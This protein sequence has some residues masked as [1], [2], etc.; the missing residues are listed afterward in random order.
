VPEHDGEARLH[1]VFDPGRLTRGALE[2]GAGC[3]CS[4]VSRGAYPFDGDL[5]RSRALVEAL[6]KDLERRTG[7]VCEDSDATGRVKDPDLL[8]RDPLAG[9]RLLCRIDA[10]LLTGQAFMA[11]PRTLGMLPREVLVI[12]EPKLERYLARAAADRAE[13]GRNVPA[14]VVWHYG[15]RCRGLT[16]VTVFQEV[17]ELDRIRERMG[18][19]RRFRRAAGGGD[20]RDGRRWGVIDKYHFSLRECRPI[21]ALA[22]EIQRLRGREPCEPGLR[23]PRGIVEMLARV[24][25]ALER[26]PFVAAAEG[27]VGV[28]GN[29]R[30]LRAT[31]VCAGGTASHALRMDY[32]RVCWWLPVSAGRAEAVARRL[33]TGLRARG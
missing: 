19:A 13:T 15:R 9:N 5:A 7:C 6:R 26:D 3:F 27:I 22:G 32:P 30:A 33:A 23:H 31:L 2:C 17:A 14:Y 4:G 12:D 11:A 28:S 1:C 18:E 25:E 16:G 20:Y 29:S 24:Q 8:V 21:E 10:K